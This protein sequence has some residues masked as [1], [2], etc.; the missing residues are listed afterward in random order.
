[1]RVGYEGR[2]SSRDELADVPP[3]LAGLR[4]RM[5][6]ECSQA[7]VYDLT[8]QRFHSAA[9]CQT[10]VGWKMTYP[11]LRLAVTL[12]IIKG[13]TNQSHSRKAR[14]HRFK[15]SVYIKASSYRSRKSTI[16]A[17]LLTMKTE[18]QTSTTRR[19]ASNNG[20]EHPENLLYSQNR[21][22][23]PSHESIP[24]RETSE[25]AGMK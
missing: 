12:R 23:I 5:G 16:E 3:V 19:R 21:L 9:K 4:Q 6:G 10:K 7:V 17:T 18:R 11:S 13:V 22:H 8:R 25:T 2:R 20:D 15:E 14:S 1:M 24:T